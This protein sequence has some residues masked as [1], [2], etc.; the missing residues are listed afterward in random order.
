MKTQIYLTLISL[1][2]FLSCNK[3]DIKPDLSRVVPSTLDDFQGILDNTLN[4]FN[5]SYNGFGEIASN[6]FYVDF[7]DFQANPILL[8]SEIY[9]F[10]IL[11]LEDPYFQDW[12]AAYLKILNCNVVLDGLDKSNLNPN[13]LEFH[14]IKGQAIFHRALSFFMLTEQFAPVYSSLNLGK[15]AIPL[16]TKSDINLNY[17]LSTVAETYKL[18]VEDLKLAASFLP[19]KSIY[20]TRPSKSSVYGLLAR[21]Y[22]AMDDYTNALKYSTAS[23]EIYS[24]LMDFNLLESNSDYPIAQFNEEVIFHGT[25]LNCNFFL[26]NVLKVQQ[27]I[28]ELYDDTDLRKEI[29]FI[30][31]I[32]GTLGFKGNYNGQEFYNMFGGIATDE[33]ILIQIECQVRLNQIKSAL[34]NLNKLLKNRYDNISFV[35]VTISDQEELLR[36]VLEERR[37]ELLFRGLRWTDLRRLNKDPRFAVTLTRKLNGVTYTLP[38]NDPRYVFPIPKYVKTIRY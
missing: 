33:I 28:I 30:K 4:T 15:P 18:I 25:I 13:D 31:N 3:L 1:S 7:N 24:A 6:D 27:S 9:K 11:N 35:T 38:P 32:D 19:E 26:R 2:L 36:R 16:R 17:P 8:T 5:L 29:L 34:E 23:L 37:K 21:V 10:N 20:K 14:N 12:N 22:L